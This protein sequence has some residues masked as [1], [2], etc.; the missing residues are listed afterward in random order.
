MRQIDVERLQKIAQYLPDLLQETEKILTQMR[1]SNGTV[2]PMIKAQLL[3]IKRMVDGGVIP[4]EKDKEK[5]RVGYLITRENDGAEKLDKYAESICLVDN[6]YTQL[7]DPPKFKYFTTPKKKA[8]FISLPCECCDGTE[9]CLDGRYF[10]QEAKTKSVCVFC[11]AEGKKRVYIPDYIKSKLR[12]HL[13]E[14]H[15]DKTESQIEQI[16]LAEINELEKTPPVPWL[17]ENEWPVANGDFARYE[18]QMG[19]GLF[20]GGKED[21]FRSLEG[22]EKIKDKDKL[23]KEVGEKITIFGFSVIATEKYTEIVIAQSLDAKT[24]KKVWG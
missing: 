4:V 6:L 10:G 13:H 23:W 16:A 24:V 5:I 11:L 7:G 20:F 22:I 9:Y 18:Y 19:K 2:Y 8:S 1:D 14:I 12:N 21:L 15:I 3:E 17:T